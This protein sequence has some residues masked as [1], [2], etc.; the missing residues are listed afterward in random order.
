MALRVEREQVKLLLVIG[1]LSV[2]VYGSW[3]AA[4]WFESHYQN[5]LAAA[6][7]SQDYEEARRLV[8]MGA[9]ANEDGGTPLMVAVGSGN[10]EFA[11]YLL[12][13]G[14]EINARQPSMFPRF[15]VL[16]QTAA[17]GR[18]DLVV[19]LV[20]RGGEYTVVA[21]ALLNDLETVKQALD[22]NS[23]LL[24]RMNVEGYPLLHLTVRGGDVE[25]AEFLLEAGADPNKVLRSPFAS[26]NYSA[27]RFA[28]IWE[29]EALLD[30]FDEWDG[31]AALDMPRKLD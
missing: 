2:F 18:S 5:P 27:R 8:E 14:A 24:A 22:K 1:V 21:A 7:M 9:N 15:S 12:D 20:E 13:N 4:R 26:N 11:Q 25:L 19:W 23:S 29:Q 30:L 10:L 31:K 16:E 6:V 28:E 3:R 17:G